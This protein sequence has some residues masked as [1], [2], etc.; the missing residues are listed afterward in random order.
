[1]TRYA[2]HPME[3]NFHQWDRDYKEKRNK[4]WARL[5]TAFSDYQEKNDDANFISFKYYMERQYGMRV[6]MVGDNIGTTYEI[7]DD[8]KYTLFLM[9]YGNT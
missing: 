3:T 7:V 4:Y 1:M 5:R 6:N 2:V 9:K 8:T